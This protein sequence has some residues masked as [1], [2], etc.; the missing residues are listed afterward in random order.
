MDEK[1]AARMVGL[2]CLL[3]SCMLVAAGDQPEKMVFNLEEVSSFAVVAHVDD[4]TRGQRADTSEKPDP[5]VKAYP[6]FQSEKPI[7]G[8][9]WFGREFGKPGSGIQYF[10]V[11]DEFSGTGKGYDRLY[12]DLDRDRDLT[13]DAPLTP[14]ENPP[15]GASLN[16][17][18]IKQ[19]VVFRCLAI[20]FDLGD[21]GK[22]AVEIMPRLTIYTEGYSGV[23]FVATKLHNG[24]ITIDGRKFDAFL[25]YEHSIGGRLDRP[26]ASLRLLPKVPPGERF[27]WWG[28]DSLTALHKIGDRHYRFS[29]TPTGDRL[30]AQPYDGE[31]GGFE[32]G[33]GKRDIRETVFHGSFRSEN[34]AVAVGGE[35]VYGFTS[36]AS[37]CRIPVGD[38]L[39][40][41]LG[42]DFGRLRIEVSENYHSD[43]KP[44][45]RE[46]RP[47][48]YGI[49]IRK[50]QPFVLDFSN[51]PAVMFASP[52]QDQR[53][54]LGEKLE[55]KAILTDPELDI[56]IRGLRDSTRKQKRETTGPDGRKNSWEEDVSLDPQVLITRADG[57]KVADGVMPFG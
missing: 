38:Y 14:L 12:F 26:P 21:E 32:V 50:D 33:P 51:K 17:T 57:E 30:F 1:A 49:R 52:A 46:D 35:I 23:S 27:Y 11:I 42:I 29:A 25:G 41:F 37:S 54:K 8:S 28:A 45:G 7:Y 5:E 34:A 15:A 43:G 9:I 22:R 13:N 3:A 47:Y 10:F 31:Y 16:Y 55:I 53:V 2:G 19:Q 20:D 48:V 44:R 40:S 18:G 39:P 36:K 56:M 24:E 6:A 4:F